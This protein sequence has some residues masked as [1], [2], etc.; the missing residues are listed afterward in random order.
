MFLGIQS[1]TCNHRIRRIHF[2]LTASISYEYE[3]TT[4]ELKTKIDNGDK[5]FLLDVREPY[6]HE[7]VN[8]GGSLIPLNQLRVRFKELDTKHEIV[9]YCHRGNRSAF[10]VNFLLQRGFSNVKNLIGGIE[11]W[12]KDVDPNLPRY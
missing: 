5:V 1:E 10:A 7:Y 6:E 8:I 4:L 12:T 3:I 2:Y 11:E 9:V